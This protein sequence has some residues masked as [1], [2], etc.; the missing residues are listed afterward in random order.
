M[1]SK[2]KRPETQEQQEA[3]AIFYNIQAQERSKKRE[4]EREEEKAGTFK[5]PLLTHPE[6]FDTYDYA[7][8]QSRGDEVEMHETRFTQ[9]GVIDTA[10]II[11]KELTIRELMNAKGVC[12][13]L[14][15]LYI[16][17]LA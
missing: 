16:N 12:L 7:N 14:F 9:P 8:V 4:R 13:I 11:A 15:Q 6:D 1:Y 5:R 2:K 17:Y 3:N 10:Q